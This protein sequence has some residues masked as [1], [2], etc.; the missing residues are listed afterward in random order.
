[1]AR[2]WGEERA[3]IASSAQ[4]DWA[5]L[6]SLP[7]QGSGGILR[8]FR[9]GSPWTAHPPPPPRPGL[10]PEVPMAS[11]GSVGEAVK[12]SHM[13][14]VSGF[15]GSPVSRGNGFRILLEA[16]QDQ[17]ELVLRLQGRSRSLHR[18]PDTQQRGHQP[19]RVQAAALVPLDT[20]EVHWRPHHLTVAVAAWGRAGLSL[21]LLGP[22]VECG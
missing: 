20:D 6:K 1:M 7:I 17:F 14:C 22:T 16:G 5:G 4:G 11:C 13:S 10:W 9:T 3:F 2:L 15:H 18:P 21:G 19:D 8:G 12:G